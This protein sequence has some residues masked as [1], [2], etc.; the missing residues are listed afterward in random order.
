M[1]SILLGKNTPNLPISVVC[2]VVTDI[3]VHFVLGVRN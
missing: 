3:R 1:S 2:S